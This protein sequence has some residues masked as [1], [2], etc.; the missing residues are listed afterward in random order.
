MSQRDNVRN[1]VL[2]TLLMNALLRWES[3]VTIL[4]TAI[5][6]ITVGDFQAF[7][8]TI[9]AWAWLV[10]GAFAEGA[11]VLATVTDPEEAQEALA[12]DF[13]S[14][15]EINHIRNRVS[16]E[17]LA[18]AFNYRRNILKLAKQQKGALRTDLMHTIEKVNDWISHMYDI[19][20]HIDNFE[21]NE[22][23]ERDLKMVP[24]RIEKTK[25][26]LERES[27][28]QVRADLEKQLQR[29][30]Q[31]RL[32]LEATKN[33]VKRAEI[34][35]ESAVSSL[36]T[37]YAQMSLLGTKGEVDSSRSQRNRLAIDDEI[38]S[39]QDTIEAMDEIQQQTMHM[40]Y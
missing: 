27:D 35:L 6:F 34:Q 40:S 25:I 17:R 36:G 7:G 30:E 21:N 16:R 2:G 32:N 39:I 10:L 29:L 3:F 22:L 37:I 9:P 19:A 8:A 24:Q 11:L 12:R 14:R 26:R 5:L 23:V 31:Q 13:E 18:T 33:S 38:A 4:V 15:Y 1:Q 28:P 20:E